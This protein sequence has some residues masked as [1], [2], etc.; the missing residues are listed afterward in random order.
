[1]NS[2]QI[3]WPGFVL[4]SKPYHHRESSPMMKH[5]GS[6]IPKAHSPGLNWDVKKTR[7]KSV[8]TKKQ[9]SSDG[10]RD[11]SRAKVTA[12]FYYARKSD[13]L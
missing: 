12:C 1:M 10:V 5:P 9:H 2:A 3:G 13:A 6:S 7:L 11:R 8:A 4:R